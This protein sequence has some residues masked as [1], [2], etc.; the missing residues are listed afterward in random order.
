MNF[1]FLSFRSV[2]FSLLKLKG[3]IWKDFRC[4]LLTNS[5]EITVLMLDKYLLKL[6]C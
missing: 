2:F 3:A 4:K 1:A 5:E 6:A